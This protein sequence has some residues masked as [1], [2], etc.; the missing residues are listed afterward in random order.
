MEKGKTPRQRAEMVF[1]AAHPPSS[2]RDRA[3]EEIDA[4]KVVRDEKTQRL[5]EARLARDRKNGSAL[6]AG[7][8]SDRA[9]KP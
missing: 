3:F 1:G 9:G 8:A 4:M 5:R 2:A 6:P 7:A